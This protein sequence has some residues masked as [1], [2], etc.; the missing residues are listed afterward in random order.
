MPE[1]RRT[2]AWNVKRKQISLAQTGE[3]LYNKM[4]ESSIMGAEKCDRKSPPAGV[5]EENRQ[6]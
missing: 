5:P 2:V 3:N 1:E 4:S 6:T